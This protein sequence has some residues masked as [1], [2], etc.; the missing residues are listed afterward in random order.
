M[1]HHTNVV[2]KRSRPEHSNTTGLVA[3]LGLRATP[4]L[5]RS[6]FEG[7][8]LLFWPIMEHHLDRNRYG[9]PNSTLLRQEVAITP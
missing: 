9:A 2:L 8:P 6:S 3:N 4:G 5:N 7:V 1:Q